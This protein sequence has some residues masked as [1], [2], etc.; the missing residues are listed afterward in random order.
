MGVLRQ[1]S[2]IAPRPVTRRPPRGIRLSLLAPCRAPNLRRGR[3]V[4]RRS[5]TTGS[6]SDP[7]PRSYSSDQEASFNR[8]TL[9]SRLMECASIFFS[10]SGSFVGSISSSTTSLL[11]TAAP[12]SAMLTRQKQMNLELCSVVW[13]RWLTTVHSMFYFAF[14]V[15]PRTFPVALELHS[16]TDR[17]FRFSPGLRH[18]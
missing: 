14:P 17:D 3:A 11:M 5:T 8:Q 12:I 9:L 2:A 18:L 4:R 6:R 15:E 7:N 13:S 1:H 16:G 10:S